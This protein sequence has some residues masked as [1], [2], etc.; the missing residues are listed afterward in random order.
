MNPQ[1][2]QLQELIAD[3]RE[4]LRLSIK[5]GHDFSSLLVGSY[6]D[7]SHFIYE[8]LQNAEDAKDE[9]TTASYVRFKLFDDKLEVYHDGKDFDFN[10][11]DAIVSI[12]KSTKQSDTESIGS[13]ELDL[14]QYMR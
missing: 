10:D 14:S 4:W 1:F 3:S 2:P 11:L 9:K 12:G 13:L 5:R 6:N 8:I 7:A